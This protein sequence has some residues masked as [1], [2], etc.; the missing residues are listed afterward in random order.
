MS[1]TGRAVIAKT[2]ADG[3]AR[4]LGL[5]TFPILA[6]LE[7]PGGYGAYAQLMTLVGFAA[8]LATFGL[9]NTMVR[10][11]SGRAWTTRRAH[12]GPGSAHWS[13]WSPC[14]FSSWCVLRSRDQ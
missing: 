4:V 3:L 13:R 2:V 6:R 8:P 7:G 11:F 5:I 9:S 12:S 14:D 1:S 10:F